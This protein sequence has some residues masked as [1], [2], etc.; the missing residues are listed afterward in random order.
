MRKL[1]EILVQH[2]CGEHDVVYGIVEFMSDAGRE[3]PD[4][5]QLVCH[6]KQLLPVDELLYH[7]VH[8]HGQLREL[9]VVL[10][11]RSDGGEIALGNPLRI[12]HHSIQR[13]EHLPG[14]EAG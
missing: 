6:H 8:G 10:L 3:S 7:V 11:S 2:R 4:R 1:P 9:V 14:D 5:L 12:S 13:R